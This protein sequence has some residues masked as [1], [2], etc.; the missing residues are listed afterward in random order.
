LA[1]SIAEIDQ[2]VVRSTA[3]AG[4]A[5]AEAC[6]ADATI[7]RLAQAAEHIGDVVKLIGGIAAQ[8]DLLALNATIEAA[9]AGDAGKGFT[10]VASEVKNLSAQTEK[11]TEDI[12]G[13]IRS[14][15][16][17]T[18]DTVQTIRSVAGTIEDISAIA[19]AISTAVGQQG[20]ATEEISRNVQEA[21]SST[22]AVAASIGSVTKS[23]DE[24]GRAAGKV[25]AAANALALESTGLRRE[26]DE[27]LASIRAA[28]P[29]ATTNHA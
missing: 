11:A 1:T 6:G 10:V 3:I 13:Q 28:S 2:Q 7:Q 25:L 22:H 27:F 18:G 20:K 4:K 9:R 21:A 16:I 5:V 12:S 23:A 29:S 17:A 8:T 24:T 26:V 15:Q 14:I 19:T